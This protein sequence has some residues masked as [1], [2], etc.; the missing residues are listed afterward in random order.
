MVSKVGAT[1]KR[2][3]LSLRTLSVETA[4]SV[5][6]GRVRPEPPQRQL[7]LERLRSRNLMAGDT[8]AASVLQYT[9]GATIAA[10]IHES[11]DVNRDGRVSALDALLVVNAVADKDDTQSFLSTFR[12]NDLAEVNISF[13]GNTGAAYYSMRLI[14]GVGLRVYS[15]QQRTLLPGTIES[16]GTFEWELQDPHPTK[17]W[18]EGAQLGSHTIRAELW[19]IGFPAIAVDLVQFKVEEMVWPDQTQDDSAWYEKVSTEWDGVKAAETWIMDRTL[20]DFIKS[21]TQQAR[22]RLSKA[23]SSLRC[24]TSMQTTMV[25]KSQQK[26]GTEMRAPLIHLAP[27]IILTDSTWSSTMRSIRLAETVR[28]VMF[29]RTMPTVHRKTRS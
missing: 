10:E 24:Q 2:V 3:A 18:V 14:V 23:A 20:V 21:R 16:T 29:K 13:Q 8:V 15:S 28:L 5:D 27:K 9:G 4:A 17:I 26:S 11:E 1:W 7:R 19:G 25:S 6:R 22:A 12:D